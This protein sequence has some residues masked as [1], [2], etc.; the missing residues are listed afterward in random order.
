MPHNPIKI[1]SIQPAPMQPINPLLANGQIPTRVRINLA[2]GQPQ[3]DASALPQNPVINTNFVRGQF[4]AG[5][6]NLQEQLINNNILK[7]FGGQPR[8]LPSTVAPPQFISQTDSVQFP[9]S[10]EQSFSS[11]YTGFGSNPANVQ[12]IEEPASISSFRYKRSDKNNNK[13]E[14]VT[15]TDGSIVDDKF[16]DTDW[17]D[18]LAQFGG[19]ALKQSLT[20]RDN[21]EE[22]IREHDREPAEGEVDAVRSYCNSCVIEPFQ[23]ALV[24]AWNSAI[25][26][27][28][29]LRAKTS[30]VCGD[31]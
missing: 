29:V 30:T 7:Q 17:Y 23:S 12:I 25:G 11:I 9:G 4:H 24:L 14:L 15:L 16:F 20:H 18:G 1:N 8:N 3:M 13:R 10:D 31:F 28:N 22:E 27:K 26:G 19:N 5:G 21:L 2:G 6:R